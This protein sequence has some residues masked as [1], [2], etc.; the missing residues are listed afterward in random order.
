MPISIRRLEEEGKAYTE[1]AW[2]GDNE[3]NLPPQID[4][5]E[6]WVNENAEHLPPGEYIAD[7]GFCWRRNAGGGGSALSPDFL[8]KMANA[9]IS[10]FLSEYPSFSDEE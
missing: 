7:V 4:L 9:G 10:L 5:L 2:L 3:W 1:V 6:S 8:G